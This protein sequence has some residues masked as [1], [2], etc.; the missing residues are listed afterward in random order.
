MEDAWIWKSKL[1]LLYGLP[2]SKKEVSQAQS[3]ISVNIIK[4]CLLDK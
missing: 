4:P 1:S 2:T 3:P